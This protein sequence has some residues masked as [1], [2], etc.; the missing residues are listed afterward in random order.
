[1][2]GPQTFS[3]LEEGGQRVQKGRGDDQ[4]TI[5]GDCEWEWWWVGK[6]CGA[7]GDGR[8]LL[9]VCGRGHVTDAVEMGGDATVAFNKMASAWP[10]R[11]PPVRSFFSSARLRAHKSDALASPHGPD[12]P[13]SNALPPLSRP[14]GVRER[15]TTLV[16]ST[17]SRL[18][19]LMDVDARMAQ[20]RHLFVTVVPLF[21]CTLTAIVARV[22]EASVGYFHDLQMT[23]KHG[24]KTWIAP[25][26]LI[27]EDVSL[28][29]M[30]ERGTE[31]DLP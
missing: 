8:V 16:K 18:K 3:R 13:P 4:R 28:A 31:P 27:R 23:R 14:L 6:E 11:S 24:G 22:K 12:A 19:E 26:V 30:C 7:S 17:T 21:G 1:M 25:E 20:R 15:P 9:Y 29:S 10:V 5:S 2:P